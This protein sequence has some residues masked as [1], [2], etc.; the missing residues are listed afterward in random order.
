MYKRILVAVD[1][2]RTSELALHEAIDLAKVLKAQLRVIHTVD[3]IGSTLYNPEYNQPSEIFES[4]AK[5]GR[6]VL[7]KAASVAAG[8]GVET[9]TKLVEIKTMGRRIPEAIAEEVEAWPADL[10]VVGTHG[11]RGLSRLFLGSVA[12]GIVRVSTKPVLLV[13][14]T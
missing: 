4:M 12:E 8:S 2:S 13:R 9:D 3:E 10:V 5:A 6:D 14:D 7:Q 1:G 11:R